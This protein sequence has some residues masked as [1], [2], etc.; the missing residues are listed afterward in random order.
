MSGVPFRV[1]G[2]GRVLVSW[3]SR[4]RI[5][6]SLSH[7][8]GVHFSPRCAAPEG[9]D[10]TSSIVLM[11]HKGEVLLV[12]KEDERVNWAIYTQDGKLT[13]EIGNAGR[14]PGGHKPT[15]FVAADDTFCIVF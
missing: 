4:N 11:N 10:Q 14:L 6:W 15:A 5:Y 2:Q 3:M 1:D 13:G 8:K 12:W 7:D 9:G